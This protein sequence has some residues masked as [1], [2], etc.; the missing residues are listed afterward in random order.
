M[1]NLRKIKVLLAILD[2]RKWL[3]HEYRNQ[4]QRIK[5]DVL[6]FQFSYQNQ[7]KIGAK[8]EQMFCFPNI[9]LS[10]DDISHLIK[11]P[12]DDNRHHLELH[13]L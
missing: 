5:N 3:R 4:H 1:E 12:N 11:F 9:F 2:Y 13:L 7:H 6:R 10:I 8:K